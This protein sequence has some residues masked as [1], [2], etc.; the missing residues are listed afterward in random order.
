MS[1][2]VPAKRNIVSYVVSTELRCAMEAIMSHVGNH[3][4]IM[5]H[6]SLHMY[7]IN[8]YDENFLVISRE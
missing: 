6:V 1:H 8:S 3:A 5:T 2:D 4:V 7:Y